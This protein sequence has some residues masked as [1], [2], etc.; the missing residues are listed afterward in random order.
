M[1][2]K[3]REEAGKQLVSLLKHYENDPQ[4]VVL[5]M[6]RGG[7]VTAYEV[8]RG[9][10]LPLD[11][12]CPR[13]IGAPFNP[14]LAIGAITETGEGI[15]DE[16]LITH[17]NVSQDY[18]NRTVANEKAQAQKRLTLYRKNLPKISLEGKTAIL[19]DDGLATGS[20]MRAA[21]RSVRAEGADKITV[22]VPVSPPDTFRLIQEEVDEAICLSTPTF[23]Q[24][25][26]QFYEDFSQ[27]EDEEV[28][29]L[30]H[31]CAAAHRS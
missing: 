30:L 18:I 3:N 7:V 14:E 27:V 25:V 4:A 9:L 2:F 26:G 28:I 6:P 12:V 19:V 1:I 16:R 15:F 24:A 8:A 11:V 21:I 23:F 5:G 17:L 10:Q 31:R 20:T 13:K 29:D 22:A